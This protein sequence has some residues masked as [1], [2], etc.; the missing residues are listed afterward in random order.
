MRYLLPNTVLLKRVLGRGSHVI[1]L[2]QV[3]SRCSM[4]IVIGSEPVLIGSL[5]D[6]LGG[7][8]LAQNV[9]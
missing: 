4:V 6:A 1:V 8:F 2:I 3:L 7:D 9:R 5:V